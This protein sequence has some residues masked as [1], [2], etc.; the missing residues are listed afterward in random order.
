MTAGAARADQVGVQARAWREALD[1][2]G[3]EPR[4][5][6]LFRKRSL[7]LDAERDGL[8]PFTGQLEPLGA[9]LLKSAFAEA[10]SSRAGPRFLSEAD[11]RAAARAATP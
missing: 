7:R 2:D 5:E 6:R 8:V 4:D 10:D 3:A 11:E 9:A 1:P